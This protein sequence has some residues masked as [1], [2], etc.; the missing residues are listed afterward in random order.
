M[1]MNATQH[2]QNKSSAF[3]RIRLAA[4]EKAIEEISQKRLQLEKQLQEGKISKNEYDQ[5]LVTLIA[6]GTKIRTEKRIIT[7]KLTL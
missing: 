6:E 4:L 3:L 2:L 5:Q 7:N 1:T